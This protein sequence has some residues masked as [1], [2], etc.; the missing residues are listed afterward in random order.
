MGMATIKR[1]RIR[2]HMFCTCWITNHEYTCTHSFTNGWQYG[3]KLLGVE[4][5][6]ADP[7][8][9]ECTSTMTFVTRKFYL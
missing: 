4:G 9:S 3:W 5:L 6:A 7:G 1:V 2:Y 8:R